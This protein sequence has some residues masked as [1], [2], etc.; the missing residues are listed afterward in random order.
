V[1]GAE[2]RPG[3]EQFAEDS[4]ERGTGEGQPFSWFLPT[5]EWRVK[6]HLNHADLETT[7]F[8]MSCEIQR[9][10]TETQ[11]NGNEEAKDTAL[12]LQW[13]FDALTFHCYAFAGNQEQ[14]IRAYNTFQA[15]NAYNGEAVKGVDIHEGEEKQTL[16]WMLDTGGIPHDLGEGDISI[17]FAPLEHQMQYISAQWAEQANAEPTPIY[18]DHEIRTDVTELME[19]WTQTEGD[20]E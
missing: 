5:L 2:Q 1:V 11:G 9:I 16:L 8:D 20:S 19:Q 13:G 18:F 4:R 14:V 10:W 15:E 7:V 6:E 3:E 17:P 12:R